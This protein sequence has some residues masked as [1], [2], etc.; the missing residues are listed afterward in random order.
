MDNRPL[1]EIFARLYRI[2]HCKFCSVK[3]FLDW[4]HSSTNLTR[5][6]WTKNLRA[7]D[8]DSLLHLQALIEQITLKE[9]TDQLVW[10][11]SMRSFTVKEC[12]EAFFNLNS[13]EWKTIWK[14]SVPP[15]IHLFL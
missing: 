10:S 12:Y 8:E 2:L 13:K 4:W 1:S 15:K 3:I 14:T 11:D 6:G 5:Q 9:G 7:G